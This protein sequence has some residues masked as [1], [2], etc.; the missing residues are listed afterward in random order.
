MVWLTGGLTAYTNARVAAADLCH[1]N[2]SDESGNDDLVDRTTKARIDP[3]K[4]VTL[5]GC[6]GVE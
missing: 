1:A 5:Q 4:L 3:L 2:Q 6:Y